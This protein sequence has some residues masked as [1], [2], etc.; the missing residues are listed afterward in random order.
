M[1]DGLISS[2][3][4]LQL[5]VVLRFKIFMS[6]Y[7]TSSKRLIPSIDNYINELALDN[8]YLTNK[9]LSPPPKLVEIKSEGMGV[10]CSICLG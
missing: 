4:V 5:L 7:A 1:N 10:E 3:N 8:Q 6:D 2:Q 9:Y